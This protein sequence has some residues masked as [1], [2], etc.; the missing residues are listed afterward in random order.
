L[1]LYISHSINDH[2]SLFI[3]R[4]T[5][6]KKVKVRKKVGGRA[7]ETK[8]TRVHKQFGHSIDRGKLKLL[9]KDADIHDKA[10]PIVSL[11]IASDVNECLAIDLKFVTSNHKKYIILHMNPKP[12]DFLAPKSLR[13]F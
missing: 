9:L 8:E 13:L 10:R 11:S 2:D 7:Q 5:L 6:I 4:I 1:C 12:H 3:I